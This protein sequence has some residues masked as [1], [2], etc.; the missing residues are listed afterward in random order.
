M[1]EPEVVDLILHITDP[2]PRGADLVVEQP[3]IGERDVLVVAD[4]LTVEPPTDPP[5]TDYDDPGI[6]HEQVMEEMRLLC[7][8]L[9]RGK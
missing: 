7:E 5:G 4:Q 8:E 6:P 9:E 3:G 2:T 1:I